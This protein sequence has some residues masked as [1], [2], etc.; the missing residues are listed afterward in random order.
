M[1]NVDTR[2]LSKVNGDEYWLLTHLIKFLGKKDSVWP[3]NKTLCKDTGWHIDKLQKIKK[4]LIDKKLVSVEVKFNT[5][6]VYRFHTKEIKI[7]I[8]VDGQELEEK[9]STVKSSR[10]SVVKNGKQSTVKSSNEVLVNE[11][12]VNEASESSDSGVQKPLFPDIE[13]PNK[14]EEKSNEYPTFIKIWMDEYKRIG[15]R[16]PRDGAKIKSLIE[17]TKSVL[18]ERGITPS[19]TNTVEFWGIF[20]K[21]LHKTWAHGKSLPVIDS[22]Y[23]SLIFELENGKTTT[24]PKKQSA[25]EWARTL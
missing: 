22:N 11:V 6:N 10:L 4:S 14:I 8:D 1:I 3:S 25:R 24:A 20:V 19:E 7:F 2:I 5:S 9:Q 21:N 15:V 17:L 23:T 13:E 18:V 16:M 12:L